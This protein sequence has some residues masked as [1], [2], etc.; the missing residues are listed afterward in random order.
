MKLQAKVLLVVALLISGV[1]FAKYVGRFYCGTSCQVGAGLASGDTYTF[2]LSVV[3]QSVDSWVDSSGNPNQMI[4]CNGSKCALYTYVKLSGQWIAEGY[5]YSNWMSGSGGGGGGGGYTIFYT[6]PGSPGCIYG[7]G[8]LW[9][10]VGP[11]TPVP[12]Q[13]EQ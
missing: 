13:K 4:L 11:V 8:D 6:N 1:A 12:G 5:Y 10:T 3:N 2:V 7:C 9:G